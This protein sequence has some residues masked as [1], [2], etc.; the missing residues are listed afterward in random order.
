MIVSWMVVKQWF[1]VCGPGTC[2][3]SIIRDLVRNA[4]SWGPIPD[5]LRQ[6]LWGGPVVCV[7]TGFPLDDADA[8]SG[9]RTTVRGHE[10]AP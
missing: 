5:L 2:S 8:G 10:V 3:M 4:D 6:R 1:S 9:S 7:F